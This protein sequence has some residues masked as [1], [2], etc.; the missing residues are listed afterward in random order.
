[1]VEVVLAFFLGCLGGSLALAFFMSV[2]SQRFDNELDALVRNYALRHQ[3]LTDE[4]I[5]TALGMSLARVHDALAP[6]YTFRAAP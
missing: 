2:F 1:M 5:A 4:E 6:L 3:D